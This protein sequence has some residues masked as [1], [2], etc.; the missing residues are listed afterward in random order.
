M[1]TTEVLENVKC[2]KLGDERKIL[3]WQINDKPLI[4]LLLLLL[5]SC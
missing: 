3:E 4:L 1:Q 2:R 5:F